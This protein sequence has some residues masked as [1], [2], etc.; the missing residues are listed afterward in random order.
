MN[1]TMQI[2]VWGGLSA[3]ILGLG[4]I[5]W[6]HM[7]AHAKL[8]MQVSQI[9]RFIVELRKMKHLQVDPYLP[10]AFEELKTRLDRLYESN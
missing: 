10:R 7:E 5:L 4:G 3:A 8:S 6:R 1:E 2:W 9:E